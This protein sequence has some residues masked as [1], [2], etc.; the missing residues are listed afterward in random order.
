MSNNKAQQ[1]G[2]DEKQEQ[3]E[4][5]M[6]TNKTQQGGNNEQQEGNAKKKRQATKTQD[7][8]KKKTTLKHTNNL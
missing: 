2:C 3:K 8:L 4:M 1:G 5:P 7:E 6:N